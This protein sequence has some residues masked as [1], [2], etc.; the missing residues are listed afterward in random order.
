MTLLKCIKMMHA[1]LS[2]KGT[3]S[4]TVLVV[5]NM[6]HHPFLGKEPHH[7]IL[8]SVFLRRADRNP[9]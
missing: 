6:A 8:P 4:D 9:L 5:L 1:I 2:S 3:Q 7:C